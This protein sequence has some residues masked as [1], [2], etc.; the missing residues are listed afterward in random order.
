[1]IFFSSKDPLWM[2]S[3]QCI[4]LR[5]GQTYPYWQLAQHILLATKSSSIVSDQNVSSSVNYIWQYIYSVHKSCIWQLFNS[6][7]CVC[8]C[9][10]VCFSLTNFVVF[11][12]KL[13]RRIF[14]F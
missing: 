3:V 13:F 5:F 8:V 6:V 10:C 1:M 12:T 2:I 4:H 9:V 11:Q 14:V 7:V